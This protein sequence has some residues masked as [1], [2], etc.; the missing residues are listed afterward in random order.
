MEITENAT[1]ITGM[2]PRY[3]EAAMEA[4]YGHHEI[5]RKL[6][7][8]AKALLR[9]I[10]GVGAEKRLIRALNDKKDTALHE[11]A[12]Y[13]HTKVVKVLIEEEQDHSYF[14]K[15]DGGETPLYIAV[16]RRN[17]NVVD[18][19]L[20][21]NGNLPQ[22]GGPNGRTA[23][24]AATIFGDREKVSKLLTRNL[25]L[26]KQADNNGCLPLHL[27][28]IVGCSETVE[29]L[30]SKDISTSY[31]RDNKGRMALHL[32][33]LDVNVSAM[34]MILKYCPDC[35]EL[36]DEKGCNAL[37]YTTMDEASYFLRIAFKE[38]NILENVPLMRNLCNERD[39]KGNTPLHYYARLAP[40]WKDYYHILLLLNFFG[41]VDTMACNKYGQNP[42]DVTCANLTRDSAFENKV[43]WRLLDTRAMLG[44]R[45]L[46]KHLREKE[47]E[48]RHD[49]AIDEKEKENKTNG[50]DDVSEIAAKYLSVIV[51]PQKYVS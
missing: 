18:T 13:G 28:A 38:R 15:N 32:A 40:K 11:A 6:I 10:N 1:P 8:C 47:Q 39:D 3:Y 33:A 16:E 26:A 50:E 19:I 7:D 17:W 22:Y 27:A 48:K 43:F 21:D 14:G 49:P 46:C 42:L 24:H 37:H 41:E 2:V 9:D 12:R 5:V 36:V 31:M 45:V 20:L 30:V 44:G 4:R 35:C 23:L 29:L 34:E 25:L 51:I